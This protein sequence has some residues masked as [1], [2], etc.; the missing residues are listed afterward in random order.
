MGVAVWVTTLVEV[1]QIVEFDTVAHV[2]TRV[3]KIDP[4]GVVTKRL[5]VVD[6]DCVV[7]TPE[8]VSVGDDEHC[9][10]TVGKAPQPKCDDLL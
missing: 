6:T 8:E 5:T 7:P 4:G 2:A 9:A 3:V 1:A 10:M